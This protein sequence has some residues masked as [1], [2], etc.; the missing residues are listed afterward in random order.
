MAPIKRVRVADDDEVIVT[1][2]AS[3]A[4][5]VSSIRLHHFYIPPSNTMLQQHKKARL[6][7]NQNAAKSRNARERSPST[8]SDEEEGQAE[9]EDHGASGPP[10]TQYDMMRD[11]DFKHLQN[12]DADDHVAEKAFQRKRGRIG[13]NVAAENGIIEEIICV[14]FMNH[15]KLRM[16]MSPL[17]NFVVGMNGSGKSAALTAI[18]LCLGGKASATNRGASLKSLIRSGQEQANLTVRIKNEGADAYQPELSGSSGYRLKSSRGRTISTKKGDVDDIIEYFNLQVDN[19][20]NVL[21]QDAAKSFIQN[22][23]PSTKYKFFVE[24]VQLQQL[25]SDYRLVS[26]T[27]DMIES[28]LVEAKEDLK[29]LER[30]YKAAAE[31]KAL[32]DQHQGT[33]DVAARM[34]DQLIWVQVEDHEARLA[35]RET[36]I[37]AVQQGIVEAENTAEEKGNVLEKVDLKIQSEKALFHEL[38]ESLGPMTEEE[39]AAKDAHG[40]ATKKVQE[41]HTQQRGIGTSMKDAEK[42]VTGYEDQITKE[43]QRIEDAN[44]GAHSRR[45][46]DLE[47][48]KQAVS[49]AKQRL[50]DSEA[51]G[52]RLSEKLKVAEDEL[53]KAE[54]AV[55]FKQSEID[56]C[57]TGLSTLRRTQPNVMDG[58]DEK[59]PRL[60]QAIQNDRSFHEQPVGP[61]GM[62]IKLLKP[63]WSQTIEASLTNALNAFIVT[64]KADQVK[65]SS[66]LRQFKM[67]FFCPIYIG[68]HNRIDTTGNEPDVQHE[69]ILRVLEFDN[70]LVRNQ[71]IINNAIEQCL[72]IPRRADCHRTM[73]HGPKPRNVKAGFSLHDTKRDCGHQFGYTG[74]NRSDESVGPLLYRKNRPRMKTDAQSQI[75]LQTDNLSHLEREKVE[76]DNRCIQVQLARNRCR[77]ACN[78][79]GQAYRNLKAALQTAQAQVE[80]LEREL[81]K[82]NVED[83]TLDVIKGYLAEAESEVKMYKETYENSV[84]EKDRLNDIAVAKKR[85][86]DA[87]KSRVADHTFALN[88]ARLKLKNKESARR[89]FLEEKNAAIDRVEQLRRD[90]VAAEAARDA[91]VGEVADYTRQA[92]EVCQ[93]VRIP[94]GETHATIQT[95]FNILLEK[96]KKYRKQL[97][98]TEQEFTEAL[99]QALGAFQRATNHYAD[100]EELLETLKQSFRKRMEGF[101]RFQRYISAAAR[102][103]FSYLL[104]NRS[105]RGKLLIDHK[106]RKL[107]VHVEPD[108]TTKSGKGRQ[109]KTLSGGEKS[110]SSICLLLALWEAMG[111]PLRC[112]DEYDVFMDDVNRDVS[113]KMIISAARASVG[114]QYI[115]ITPKALGSGAADVGEDVKIHKLKDP[116]PKGQLQLDDMM[117]TE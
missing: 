30:K 34:R 81:E 63:M 108:E 91:Q 8:S 60:L 88:K 1:E 85:D 78:N 69:T 19:P 79:H 99:E 54:A 41:V 98:G 87:A 20:M 83:G 55:K 46:A 33:K 58:Y 84:I 109:T 76:L 3:S 59:M 10:A 77:S 6:S 47:K 90:L 5:R 56:E 86:L 15:T 82:D 45:L 36:T 101:W 61:L 16:E 67:D 74:R 117:E 17:I 24:G 96:I 65:L 31:K 93:R 53:K 111:S 7:L 115:M 110:F 26:D 92:L 21:T 68:N 113:T 35:R 71:L 9:P 107:D 116:Q 37:T 48:A 44:G 102:I 73:F 13:Q 38:E 12:P 103:A 50:D 14:N 80:N 66:I 40:E 72:L 27:C 25:D 97:G 104:S 11:N 62:H 4:L 64:S 94:E 39:D 42:R 89:N 49:D 112:L 57:R 28:K 29:V 75:N 23:T 114:R 32:I 105:F 100:M 43:K 95:K 70:D 22:S 51:E 106:N 2:S 52:P 18:T